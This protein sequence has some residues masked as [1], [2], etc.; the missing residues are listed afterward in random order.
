MDICCSIA[1]KCSLNLKA[2]LNNRSDI[3]VSTLLQDFDSHDK[4]HKCYNFK[5]K[6]KKQV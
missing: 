1:D 6:C 4:Q 2:S 5:E 3:K